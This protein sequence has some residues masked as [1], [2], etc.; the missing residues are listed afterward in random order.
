MLGYSIPGRF[1]AG[2]HS[3]LMSPLFPSSLLF[4]P[5]ETPMPS[6]LFLTQLTGNAQKPHSCA[7][8]LPAKGTTALLASF[9][10]AKLVFQICPHAEAFADA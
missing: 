5:A 3:A 4:S 2:T 7:S 10:R 1:G 6:E 8:Q 9:P